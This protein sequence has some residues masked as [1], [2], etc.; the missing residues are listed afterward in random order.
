MGEAMSVVQWLKDLGQAGLGWHAA[1]HAGLGVGQ[2]RNTVAGIGDSIMRCQGAAF[3]TCSFMEYAAIASNGAMKVVGNYGVNGNKTSDILAR[4]KNDVLLANA[5]HVIVMEAANDAMNG[6]TVAQH[7]TNMTAIIANIKAAGRIPT[8]VGAPPLNSYNLWQY[9]AA[10]QQLCD[11][12]GVRYV[13][14]WAAVTAN[15]AWIDTTYSIDGV[16]PTP[17]SSRIAG[18]ALWSMLSSVF[19]GSPDLTWTNTDPNGLI[20][21]GLFLNSSGGVPI[22]WTGASGVTHSIVAT[23]APAIGNYWQIAASGLS[24]WAVSTLTGLSIPSG[25]L[26][27]DTVRLSCR[28][29]T[30]GYE[31]NGSAGNVSYPTQGKM[32]SYI[33]LSWG[34]TSVN[35]LLR[36]IDGDVS[37]VFSVDGVIPGGATGAAMQVVLDPQASASGTLQIAQLQVHNLSLLARM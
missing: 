11:S 33:N 17:K 2:Y 37:G 20:P 36:E 34:G 4:M 35:L 10:D 18:A 26:A 14:P 23:S 19:T 21:N 3:D 6:I 29:N 25:W 27:G 24:S 32:G 5:L 31:A 1:E 13:N 16:H 8:V 15:G 12:L 9:N 28:V 7:R 22:G 30:L